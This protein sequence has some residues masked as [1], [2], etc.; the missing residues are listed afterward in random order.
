MPCHE[1]FEQQNE[2]YKKKILNE[3]SLLVSIE[4]S[5]SSFWKRYTG[6]KGLNFGINS[7]GKSAPYKK[8]YDYFGLNADEI[9]KQIK[10][11]I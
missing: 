11:K 10:K 8:I 4:A 6:N 2:R 1:L 7:F 3:T 9:I 5:E